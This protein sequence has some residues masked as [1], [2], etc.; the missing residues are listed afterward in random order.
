M[1]KKLR[2][3]CCLLAAV[4]LLAGCSKAGQLS[5]PKQKQTTEDRNQITNNIYTISMLVVGDLDENNN[6]I[7]HRS[8]E[9]LTDVDFPLYTR[10]EWNSLEQ[11]MAQFDIYFRSQDVYTKA[12]KTY[13]DAKE[14]SGLPGKLIMDTLEISEAKDGGYNATVDISCGSGKNIQLALSYNEDMEI[15]NV[16]YNAQYS[17]GENLKK[18][19]LN[20][21]LGMGT[22]FVILILI[23][24]IISIFGIF[25]KI[26]AARKAKEAQK[27]AAAAVKEDVKA[28]TLPVLEEELS[29]DL[30]LVAVISAA[31][32]AF[33]GSEEA[34]GYVVRSI[35]KS[36]K[37]QKA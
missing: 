8:Y 22:V 25:P 13:L 7:A 23:S 19:G 24:L 15:T 2:I 21:L 1:K 3:L 9:D 10:G 14:D 11:L 5:V 26:E 35:K 34:S 28:E 17:I 30:E 31:I 4:F 20:T 33:E 18:A 32:A 36:K 29:D 12:V 27:H 16:A 6:F 37:W